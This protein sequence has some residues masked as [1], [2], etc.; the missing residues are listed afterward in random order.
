MVGRLDSKF[1][2]QKLRAMFANP[3]V[4]DTDP[5]IDDALAL[6]MAFSAPNASIELVTTVAGNT[7]LER[8]TANASLLLPLFGAPDSVV[9]ASGASRPL[10]RDFVS[11]EYFHGADGLGG[12]TEMLDDAG[13]E[14]A[15]VRRNAVGRLVAAANRHGKKLTI[16]ALGPLTN[17]ARAIQKDAA[18]MA[19]IGRLVVMGGALRVAGNTTPASEFNFFA[20]PDAAAIVLGAGLPLTLV[21]LDAT[22]QVRL[23][24][25]ALRTALGRRRDLRARALRHMT[26]VPFSRHRRDGI[27]LHDPLAIAAALEPGL[28]RTETVSVSIICERGLTAGMSLED[29]RPY[30]LEDIVGHPVEVAFGADIPRALSLFTDLCLRGPEAAGELSTNRVT[31]VGGANVDFMVRSGSL[32]RPGETVSGDDMVQ[33]DGGKGA[34]QAVAARRAGADVCFI[35]RVGRDVLGDRTWAQLDQEGIDVSGVSRDPRPTG[36]ALIAVDRHGQNQISVGAGANATLTPA[37]VQASAGL[38]V[39]SRVLVTQLESPIDA[40]MEAL[41]IAHD[42]GVTTVLNPA[43]VRAVPAELAALVDVLIANEVEAEALVAH[44]VRT[45]PEVRSALSALQSLGFQ[46]PVI[47]LGRRGVMYRDCGRFGREKGETVTSVDAT[48][49]GDTFVGYVAAGLASGESLQAAIAV[50]N[51]AAA[52]TVTRLG[53][54]PSIPTRGEL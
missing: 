24:E 43:P 25:Q 41:R 34:N 50:A 28:L 23:T 33:A 39:G 46:R 40:V 29:R 21:P 38:L 32:P 51:R 35:G 4:I 5:G 1:T 18:A 48:A 45:V 19:G 36:V 53:A 14:R 37:L 30:R 8:G 17:I 10:R 15:P 13:L 9:L 22:E 26:R 20:D 7:T 2:V 12:A 31:V 49:A 52:M 3:I 44:P 27:A 42:A 47:T 6:A 16:V 54:Q 11:A